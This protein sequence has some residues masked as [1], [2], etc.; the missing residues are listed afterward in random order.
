M[1]PYPVPIPDPGPIFKEFKN[2][3]HQ[4]ITTDLSKNIGLSVMTFFGLAQ[5]HLT[6]NYFKEL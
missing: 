1:L 2:I 4:K 6:K 5:M 3:L